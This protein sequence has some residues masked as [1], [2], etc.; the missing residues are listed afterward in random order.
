MCRNAVLY[1]RVSYNLVNK[2]KERGMAGRTAKDVERRIAELIVE[3]ERLLEREEAQE[4]ERRERERRAAARLRQRRRLPASEGWVRAVYR[5]RGGK[6]HG[7]YWYHYYWDQAEG[8]QK[9]RYVGRSL[10]EGGARALAW[11]EYRRYAAEW[12]RREV[13]ALLRSGE[14]LDA[15]HG[16][17]VEVVSG[18]TEAEWEAYSRRVGELVGIAPEDYRHSEFIPEHSF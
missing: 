10:D 15:D 12:R 18:M 4:R 13:E 9:T 8:R 6:K 2:Q 17:R 7:P 5:E 14:H 1:P 3:R 11:E 16:G